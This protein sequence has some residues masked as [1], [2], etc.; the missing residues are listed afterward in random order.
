MTTITQTQVRTNPLKVLETIV[1][2]GEEVIF[3]RRGAEVLR[4]GRKRRF[5][6]ADLARQCKLAN[7]ADKRDPVD[8]FGDW[9]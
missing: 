7:E 6:R 4:I 5:T 9:P 3:T 2:S 1:N 8:D